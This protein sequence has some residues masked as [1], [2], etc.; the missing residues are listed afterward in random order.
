MQNGGGSDLKTLKNE[1]GLDKISDRQITVS[2]LSSAVAV[3]CVSQTGS[4]GASLWD[5]QIL[6]CG[7]EGG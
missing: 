2:A 1:M 7:E 3:L 4:F 5:S 6:P